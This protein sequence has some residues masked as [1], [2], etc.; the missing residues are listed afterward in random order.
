MLL[1]EFCGKNFAKKFNLLRHQERFHQGG[2]TVEKCFLCGQIFEN[3]DSLQF[4]YINNHKG[5]KKFYAI[6]NAFGKTVLTYRCVFK[7]KVFDINKD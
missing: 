2:L 3:S 7:N 6:E 1:C 4:H 5:S